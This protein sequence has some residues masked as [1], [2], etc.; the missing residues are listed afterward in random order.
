MN[1]MISPFYYTLL[2]FLVLE[3]GA[4]GP[5]M[6]SHLLKMDLEHTASHLAKAQGIIWQLCHA[7]RFIA[8]GF[9]PL[10]SDL[11]REQGLTQDDIV[12]GR[13]FTIDRHMQ[14][15][16][17]CSLELLSIAE[18][19]LAKVKK[20]FML[21]DTRNKK[22][23]RPLF[24]PYESFSTRVAFLQRDPL[25]LFRSN[26]LNPAHYPISNLFNYLSAFHLNRWR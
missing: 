25:I 10:P 4:A 17:F 11:L 7:K 21:K 3:A 8:H 9:C 2:E 18:G 6:E 1:L 26:R 5:S 22:P 15:F 12:S 20:E 24:L 19:H 13:F 16:G 23:F 14:S